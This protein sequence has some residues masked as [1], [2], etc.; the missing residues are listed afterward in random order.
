[1]MGLK[2]DWRERRAARDG[3][4]QR[5]KRRGGQMN[6]DIVRRLV[7]RKKSRDDHKKLYI[8]VYIRDRPNNLTRRGKVTE[9]RGCSVS[10]VLVI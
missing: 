9:K 6:R 1:M 4:R 7:K 10:F 3:E 2:H 5:R 8:Y